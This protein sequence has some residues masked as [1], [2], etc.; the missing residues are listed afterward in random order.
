MGASELKQLRQKLIA[1]GKQAEVVDRFI[2]AYGADHSE[3][4]FADW[5]ARD[6]VPGNKAAQVGYKA[7]NGVYLDPVLR[8]RLKSAPDD[9][10]EK[11]A[12]LV[13][14]LKVPES[15]ADVMRSKLGV[16]QAIDILTEAAGGST[17]LN[18]V[19]EVNHA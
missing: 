13:I 11:Y 12:A 16:A 10:S 19:V 5:L 8:M 14:A 9:T 15:V 1:A 3:K 7:S 6:D 17:A 4:V 18:Y 2:E